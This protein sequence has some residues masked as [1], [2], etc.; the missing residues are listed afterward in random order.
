MVVDDDL[1]KK[2]LQSSLRSTFF[3]GGVVF[4][5]VAENST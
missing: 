4:D 1:K 2:S 3:K 5:L